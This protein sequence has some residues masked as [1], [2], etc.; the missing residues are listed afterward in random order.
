MVE[1]KARHISGAEKKA[2]GQQGY[3]LRAKVEKVEVVVVPETP[4]VV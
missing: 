2:E 3:C 1:S 4:V